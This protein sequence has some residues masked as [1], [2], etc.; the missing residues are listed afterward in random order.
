VA[1]RIRVFLLAGNRL[2]REALGRILRK[3]PD[4]LLSGEASGSPDVSGPFV[5][6]ETDVLLMDGATTPALNYQF[7]SAVCRSHP[8][9]QVVLIGMEDSES[10]FLEAVRAG[11]TGYLLKNASAT[12]VI[13][14]IRAVSQGE[15]VCPPRLCRTLFRHIVEGNSYVP[16]IRMHREL[17]LTRRQLELV[18]MIARGLT[19]KEIASHLNLSEQTIKNHIH[20]MLRKVGADDRL[21]VA[22]IAMSKIS[23]V[24]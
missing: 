16:S 5:K 9:I 22:E 24:P 19:N 8:G 1:P 20:R 15:A 4:I 10:I 18:P 14:A 3:R 12:E 23:R 13:T 2:L 11:V 17:G 21:E 7:I 6:L